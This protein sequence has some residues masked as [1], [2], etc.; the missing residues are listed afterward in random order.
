MKGLTRPPA[1]FTERHGGPFLSQQRHGE[2]AGEQIAARA[3][4]ELETLKHRRLQERE[5]GV[6]SSEKEERKKLFFQSETPTGYY[7]LLFCFGSGDG[8]GAATWW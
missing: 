7:C 1:Y 8:R 2:I 3:S 6:V 4:K 5:Q